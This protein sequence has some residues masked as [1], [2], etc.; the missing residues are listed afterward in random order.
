MSPAATAIETPATTSE[1]LERTVRNQRS[2][3]RRPRVNM[4][5]TK[6]ARPPK[7]TPI[8]LS[9]MPPTATPDSTASTSQPTASFTIAAASVIW[10]KLRRS[11]PRSER[12]FPTTGSADTDSARAKKAANTHV[13]GSVAPAKRSPSARPRPPVTTN[14]AR[15]EPAATTRATPRKR[16]MMPRSVS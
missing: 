15:S 2:R 8:R 12:I 9:W 11:T 13:G 5:S 7:E 10:P 6:T 14:G 4:N 3:R 1:P 16:A